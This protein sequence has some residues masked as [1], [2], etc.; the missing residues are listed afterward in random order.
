[1]SNWL[2]I[3]KQFNS[4]V[5]LHIVAI[6]AAA[7]LVFNWAFT[8]HHPW[9]LAGIV[10]LDWFL[11]NLL[12]RVVDLPEDRI[13][14]IRGVGFVSRH[15]TEILIGGVSLLILSFF[16]TFWR[17]PQLIWW[18]LAFHLLGF[19]YNWPLLPRGRRIKELYFW[20][21]TASATG[22]IITLFLYPWAA[23]LWGSSAH[24][25]LLQDISY[26]T[27]LFTAIYFFLF[28]LSYEVLYDLRDVE[29]DKKASIRT[30]P[31]VHSEKTAHRIID[32][33]L[34]ISSIILISGY[35]LHWVPWRI[36]VMVAAPILQFILYRKAI[37]RGIDE[38]HCVGLT[39]FG[40]GLLCSYMLWV[41]F[42]LP[43]VSS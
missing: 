41:F 39:W 21:N 12:N 7:L 1:M 20:K 18:R 6:A 24:S 40:V 23:G 17:Q 13:N 9:L 3:I 10:A 31:V 15:R 5:R 8:G 29:G 19:A 30:Y 14:D 27:I 36:V 4:I 38:F 11:V 32:F 42:D 22:F 25:A 28:E 34:F 2:E 37:R 43:G 33:L 16:W 26:R 35:L